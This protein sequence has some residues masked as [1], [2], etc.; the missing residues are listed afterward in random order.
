MEIAKINKVKSETKNNRGLIEIKKE[1][2]FGA[3]ISPN[4]EKLPNN[5]LYKPFNFTP[6]NLLN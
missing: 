1:T 2:K 3:I 5:P 6:K 4:D